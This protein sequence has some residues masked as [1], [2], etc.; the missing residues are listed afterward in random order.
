MSALS[1]NFAESTSVRRPADPGTISFEGM[2]VKEAASRALRD[3][4]NDRLGPI[5]TE[6]LDHSA[7]VN[8][9][10]ILLPVAQHP[11]NFLVFGLMQDFLEPPLQMSASSQKVRFA[12]QRPY[13]DRFM[14]L[15]VI[16]KDEGI[17]TVMPEAKRDFLAFVDGQGFT[18]RRASLALLDDGSLGATWRNE[19]WRL[20]LRFLGDN[21]T[22]YVLLDRTNPPAGT[23]GT[24]GLK[25]FT[26]DYEQLDIRALLTE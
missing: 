22:S 4:R 1:M 25:N 15:S 7:Y 8:A 26:I 19:Q 16:A 23:T 11:R 3:I 12:S 5:Q 6:P 13:T 9:A 14:E 18:V 10:R 24:A 21:Q 17:A 2:L 20:D